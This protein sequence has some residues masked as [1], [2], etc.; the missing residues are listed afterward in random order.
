M[1][2]HSAADHKGVAEMHAGHGGEGIYKVATH[3]NRGCFVVAHRVEETVFRWKQ[4]R[5]HAGVKGKGNEGEEVG[6][7]ESAANRGE[8]GVRGRD[9]I[10][11]S[12]K[13]AEGVRSDFMRRKARDSKDG[14]L[15][16]EPYCAG[17]MDKSIGSI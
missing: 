14:K 7:G 6:K 16:D 1:V 8:R 11:P 15:G 2:D 4:A 13:A 3:P 17:Y 12:Y 9:I 5:W 10:I